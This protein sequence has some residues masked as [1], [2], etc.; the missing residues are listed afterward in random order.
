MPRTTLL[1]ADPNGIFCRVARFIAGLAVL[2]G[3]FS[4]A[5]AEPQHSE[6]TQPKI[7]ELLA[8]D[9]GPLRGFIK[10]LEHSLLS[11]DL[12]S[13]EAVVDQ[14]AILTRATQHCG[15]EG[16]ETVRNIFCDSTRRSWAETG[17]TR[18]YCNTRFRYL[19]PL[20][21][22]NRA[23]LLFR[24]SNRTGG[25][26]YALFTLLEPEP[27][28]FRVADIFIVGL[29]EFLSDTLRRT[30]INVAAGFLG[31]EASQL[32]GVNN[33]YVTHINEIA[34]MS[35][36]MNAGQ[37]EEALKSA[38]AL[39]QSVQRERSVLLIRME[40]AERVSLPE[41]NAV[42]ADW[43]AAY[44][45]EMDLPLKLTHFYT[46][47]NRFEDA[48][49]VL[50][51]LMARLGDDALLKM[52]IGSLMQRQAQHDALVTKAGLSNR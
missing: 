23:G 20:T 30:W 40:A 29:N 1:T 48:E 52:E 5:K 45:D 35:R 37:F 12:P 8:G 38:K 10:N 36:Q 44:P 21:L 25:I 32:K 13:A 24:S 50:R 26:N 22:K 16:D 7:E 14:D 9:T 51:S 47:Q 18:D 42:Y 43:L 31:D 33:E 11:G 28:Q 2:A 39:P 15:F 34:D 3:F 41:R 27:G 19:R 4:G 17:V 49:R 46:T 6:L